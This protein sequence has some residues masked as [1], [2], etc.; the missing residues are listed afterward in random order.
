MIPLENILAVW[1]RYAVY[2]VTWV[3]KWACLEMRKKETE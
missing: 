3:S 1:E 2:L